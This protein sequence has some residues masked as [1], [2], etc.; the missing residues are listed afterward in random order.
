MDEDLAQDT[1][2]LA[3]TRPAMM[4]GLPLDAALMIAVVATALLL[5]L[6]NPII[7]LGV[8]VGLWFTGRLVVRRDYNQFRVFSLW[9]RT[10][11]GAPNK[12]IW[13][14]SSYAPLPA[15]LMK[16]KGFARV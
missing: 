3:L 13:S 11:M 8:G 7:A 12:A 16:R 1:L 4:W 6:G 15:M 9:G 10:K 5:G 14:G 2:F